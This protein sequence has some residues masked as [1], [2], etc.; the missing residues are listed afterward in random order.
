MVIAISN[1]ILASTVGH[2]VH[3]TILDLLVVIPSQ[4]IKMR[5]HLPT[6]WEKVTFIA[7]KQWKPMQMN[8]GMGE[9]D[10]EKKN[11]CN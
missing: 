8:E 6:E 3:A 1:M 5:L 7:A 10:W 4:V 11:L 2:M 9:M